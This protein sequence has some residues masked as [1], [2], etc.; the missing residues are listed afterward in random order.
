MTADEIQ[1]HPM[2]VTTTQV[3]L[4]PF[5]NTAALLQACRSVA[6]REKNAHWECQRPPDK[7]AGDFA[8]GRIFEAPSLGSPRFT[9]SQHRG[10]ASSNS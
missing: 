9:A 1:S 3:A 7:V 2:S 5:W 6:L 8:L 4:L 10:G